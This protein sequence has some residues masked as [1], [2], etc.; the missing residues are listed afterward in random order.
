MKYL[1]PMVLDMP[2]EPPFDVDMIQTDLNLALAAGAEL[3]VPLPSTAI[4]NPF[5]NA[6]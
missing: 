2:E 3:K 6:A 4:T 5:L 1:F